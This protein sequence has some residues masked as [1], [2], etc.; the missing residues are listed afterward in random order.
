MQPRTST[1][2]HA[3]QVDSMR[4]GTTATAPAD[5]SGDMNVRR[6]GTHDARYDRFTLVDW[7]Q[8]SRVTGSRILVV[9]AGA[10]GSE[11]AR[12]AGLLGIG[13]IGVVDF[14][15][16]EA[17]NLGRTSMFRPGDVGRRKVDVVRE[18]VAEFNP[19]VA[20]RAFDGDV[21]FSIG[22]GLVRRMDAVFG[23]IDTVE[24]R[25]HVNRLCGRAG[26]PWFDGGMYAFIGNNAAWHPAHGACY[27][28]ALSPADLARL[29]D[30]NRCG[31]FGR[32]AASG[33]VPTFP[34]IASRV[35]ADLMN[36]F[37]RHRLNVGRDIFTRLVHHNA[38]LDLHGTF[39]P[40]APRRE[41][42]GSHDAPAHVEVLEDI[43]ADAPCEAFARALRD[44]LGATDDSLVVMP[45]QVV[46]ALRCRACRV[47]HRDV[48]RPPAL[49]DD[50]MAACER[51]GTE[52]EPVPSVLPGLE[53]GALPAGRTLRSLGFAPWD[54]ARVL[55]GGRDVVVE[56]GGDAL[57]ELRAAPSGDA[58]AQV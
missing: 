17:T 32:P 13:W 10:V 27:E 58:L 6:V 35:A 25:R 11:V 21:L 12:L 57:P 54:W 47:E 18:R 56:L 24:G 14:D 8:Q 5:V 29:R 53:L 26:V 55:I 36:D 46:I 4:T 44:R 2:E 51:C 50:A 16:I 7:W 15:P 52:L 37:I 43:G 20:V 28:C 1:D 3:P 34:T 40:R 41:G 38:L 49:V 30:R 48:F 19:T 22:P 42:C 31:P 33:H 45:H 39:D 9:G 23:A